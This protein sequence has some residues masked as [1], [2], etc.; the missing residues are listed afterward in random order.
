MTCFISRALRSSCVFRQYY[1][2]L[3]TLDW[4]MSCL[5][6]MIDKSWC[7]TCQRQSLQKIIARESYK[8]E[9]SENDC[10]FYRKAQDELYVMTHQSLSTQRYT[11]FH[12][13]S[14]HL[15]AV[16]L[17]LR[18]LSLDYTQPS[19]IAQP[20]LIFF[21]LLCSLVVQFTRC[22]SRNDVHSK[23]STVAVSW[24]IVNLHESNFTE[25]LVERLARHLIEHRSCEFSSLKLIVDD[26]S[27]VHGSASTRLRQSLHELRNFRCRWQ[28]WRVF[29]KM[30]QNGTGKCHL[31]NSQVS[32]QAVLRRAHA[33][34]LNQV[35]V[36][37][38]STDAWNSVKLN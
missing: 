21:P 14:H 10:L 27:I 30:T 17:K 22:I 25:R 16:S 9:D 23:I 12:W 31:F 37:S 1:S 11:Q 5:L 13:K 28:E 7:K 33:Y 29:S 36:T 38:A 35:A 3:M 15:C 34:S 20:S 2:K 8:Q 24:I 6:M 32:I 4:S 26:S 18:K 19:R